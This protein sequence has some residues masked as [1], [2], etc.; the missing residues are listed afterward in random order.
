MENSRS[1][2]VFTKIYKPYKITKIGSVY[3]FNTMDG[4][5][6]IKLNPKIDY[7]KLY[8]Y[9]YS[10]SFSYVPSL[11]LDSRDDML[12]LE[13]QEDVSTDFNQKIID[14][15]EVVGLLHSKTS[16]YKDVTIDRY[17]E[18]YQNVHDNL[19]YLEK[20][21]LDYFNMY[22]ENTYYTPSEYLFLR[23][24][25]VIDGAI[26]YCLDNLSTWYSGVSTKNSERVSLI[27]NNLKLEHFIR[28]TDSYLVSWDNYTYDSIVLDLFKLYRND[29]DKVSFK[30]AIS[31]YDNLHTMLDDERM[32][33]NILI[34]MPF[35]ID[36]NLGEYEKC[37]EIR[38]LIMYLDKSA[39][40]VL[41]S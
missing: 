12:V 10:R 27:H 8:N 41:D 11:S 38:R 30:E 36:M 18:V 15:M 31:T 16:Y 22:L 29:W 20:Y 35:K 17:K 2:D 34:S 33:F 4:D 7:K 13:Y 6:V 21:Y 19:L 1:L 26:S 39:K 25:S 3:L 23:S 28:N 5:F 32:L 40:L 9:L 24:Y 14:M 37:R